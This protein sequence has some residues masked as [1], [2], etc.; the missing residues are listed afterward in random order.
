MN[1]PHD[2]YEDASNTWS[3]IDWSRIPDSPNMSTDI[4]PSRLHTLW[5]TNDKIG[6]A[7]V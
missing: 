3:E 4:S 7:H 5:V 2:K 6:R 1:S